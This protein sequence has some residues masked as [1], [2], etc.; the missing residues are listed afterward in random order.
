MSSF[1][2]SA[3]SR[4]ESVRKSLLPDFSDASDENGATKFAHNCGLFRSQTARLLGNT[5][6]V[7]AVAERL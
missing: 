5:R 2:E 4:D 7:A 1:C 3:N 6:F